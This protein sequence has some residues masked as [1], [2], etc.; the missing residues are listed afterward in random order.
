M[1]Q[2]R[3]EQDVNWVVVVYV[4]TGIICLVR[5]LLSKLLG[6]PSISLQE[7]G[8]IL[9]RATDAIHKG[10]VYGQSSLSDAFELEYWTQEYRSFEKILLTGL[11]EVCGDDI[12]FTTNVMYFLQRHSD[13]TVR[14]WTE[15]INFVALEFLSLESNFRD[16]YPGVHGCIEHRSMLLGEVF[17]IVKT[18]GSVEPHIR[19]P[20]NTTS[21]RVLMG[22]PTV[23]DKLR[24]Q[25]KSMG[26]DRVIECHPAYAYAYYPDTH[27][28]MDDDFR[29]DVG[30]EA[31]RRVRDYFKQSEIRSLISVAFT[32]D[33]EALA[34]AMSGDE[35][36]PPIAVLN[37]NAT[38]P[39]ALKNKKVET[40][41]LQ[42]LQVYILTLGGWLEKF[43][44]ALE[45]RILE[46]TESEEAA[47]D[48]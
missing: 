9:T 2:A 19:I 48:K 26:E 36:P 47:N 33:H 1:Q 45:S 32:P 34:R 25:Q 18:E 6:S 46:R 8:T 44:V 21:K 39:D 35:E 37:I 15:L 43:H 10:Q 13:E 40:L 20:V 24:A 7:L 16:E 28:L 4:G 29:D 22:A 38:E 5:V 3:A 42:S 31:R 30:E 12:E 14:Q 27:N 17:T 23:V 41:V 11:R